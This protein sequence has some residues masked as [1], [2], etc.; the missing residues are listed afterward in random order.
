MQ[1]VY[2]ACDWLLL[3]EE[4]IAGGFLLFEIVTKK[5]FGGIELFYCKNQRLKLGRMPKAPVSF[6]SLS[7]GNLQALFCFPAKK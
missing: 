4:L 3:S 5:I 6:Y 2:N 7:E 1:Y